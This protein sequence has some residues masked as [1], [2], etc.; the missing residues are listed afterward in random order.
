[1][2]DVPII[3]F[4]NKLDREARDPFDLLDEIEQ[5]LALEVTPASWPIG[6]G[7][8]FLGTYD[9]FADVL[10]LFERGATDVRGPKRRKVQS[11]AWQNP[12][13][14]VEICC[15]HRPSWHHE[16]VSLTI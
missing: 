14:S 7:R 5:G 9:L 3:T 2:R 12:R 15:P 6:T 4:V 1:L 8:D 10:L 13:D 11:L 16:S